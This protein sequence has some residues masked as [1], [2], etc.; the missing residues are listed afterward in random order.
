MP[1]GDSDQW[2]RRPLPDVSDGSRRK[3]I[4]DLRWCGLPAHE[5]TL[6]GPRITTI[7]LSNPAGL[8][9]RVLQ[10]TERCPTRKTRMSLQD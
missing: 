3:V 6:R 10:A 2:S 7:Q 1:K 5:A 8:A 4:P 9:G